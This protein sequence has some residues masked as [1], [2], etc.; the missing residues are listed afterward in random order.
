V[1]SA[2]AP[3]GLYSLHMTYAG[4]ADYLPSSSPVLYV[5]VN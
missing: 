1:S 5:T 2:G 4:S 3:A